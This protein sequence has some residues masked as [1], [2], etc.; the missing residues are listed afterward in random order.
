MR[1]LII[2]LT[3]FSLFGLLVV[4]PSRKAF[5]RHAD[6]FRQSTQEPRGAGSG[7]GGENDV[8]ELDPPMETRSPPGDNQL[9]LPM[10]LSVAAN[11]TGDAER[12]EAAAPILLGEFHSGGRIGQS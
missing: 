10:R 3:I 5:G 7:T 6:P 4:A 11:T 2:R 8:R 12:C 1:Q 9:R